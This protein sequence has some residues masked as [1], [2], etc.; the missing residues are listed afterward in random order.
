MVI[1]D[2]PK[3]KAKDAV[4]AEL[5]ETFSDFQIV[6]LEGG[7][8]SPYPKVELLRSGVSKGPVGLKPHLAYCADGPFES[9]EAPVFALDDY[10][11]VADLLVARLTLSGP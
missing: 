9:L 10:Q 6:L 1:K 3:A 2:E 8:N 4:A 7:K 5:I 11:G